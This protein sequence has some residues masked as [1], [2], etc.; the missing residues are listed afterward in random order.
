M[1]ILSPQGE[2]HIVRDGIAEECGL[3]GIEK[4]GDVVLER[5]PVPHGHIAEVLRDAAGA[6]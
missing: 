4:S 3:E 6:G 2:D 5:K 1:G